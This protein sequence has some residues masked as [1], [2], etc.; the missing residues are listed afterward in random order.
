MGKG[1]IMSSVPFFMVTGFLGSG[2]TTLLKRFI[3]SY[4][5]TI[6]I[7]VIQNEFSAGHTDSLELQRTNKKFTLMEINRGSVFCVCLLG[8][9][10]KQFTE[11]INSQQFD[12]IILEATGLADPI[13]VGQ[14]LEADSLRGQV[15]LAHIW[16]VVDAQNFL[17]Y[18]QNITR[19]IHQ[20]RI[21]DTVLVNKTDL[22]SNVQIIQDKIRELNPFAGIRTTQFCSIP[23][24]EQLAEYSEQARAAQLPVNEQS[25]PRP[26]I[27]SVVIRNTKPASRQK[28]QEFLKTVEKKVYRLKGFVKLDDGEMA[29]VQSCFGN[30][31]VEY[32][33]NN[34]GQ[35]ELIALGP[36][37]DSQ[38]FR[39]S[40]LFYNT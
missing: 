18:A 8:D 25:G 28:L 29:A 31:T 33:A 7:A 32:I 17:K 40:F 26:D 34:A 4:A 12:A 14:L 2:K 11:L 20:V 19:V 24:T 10:V 27:G 36:G 30:T 3:D 37:L 1:F 39:K 22:V 13:A 23:F 5:D 6:K 38:E 21:A 9:F 35:T 16:C 15:H